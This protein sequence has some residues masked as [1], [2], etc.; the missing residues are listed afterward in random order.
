MTTL[1]WTTNTGIRID[2]GEAEAVV[3]IGRDDYLT[4]T[5]D[6]DATRL[7]PAALAALPEVQAELMALGWTPPPEPP[8][9]FRQP[10]LAPEDQKRL[11]CIGTRIQSL[12]EGMAERAAAE[13]AAEA[14]FE[15]PADHDRPPR[16]R[17]G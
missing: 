1:Q 5:T 6:P 11:D 4:I 14:A 12:A 10:R 8:V 16:L 17:H 2:T 3:P 15:A 7:V 9:F 13:A